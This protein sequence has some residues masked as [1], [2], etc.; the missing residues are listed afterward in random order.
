MVGVG[1]TLWNDA[2][3][4]VQAGLEDNKIEYT[5]TDRLIDDIVTVLVVTVI[6]A[7]LS[8]LCVLS[9][10]LFY[11]HQALA[12][13]STG[14]LYDDFALVTKNQ[15]WYALQAI[16]TSMPIA[17]LSVG[18]ILYRQAHSDMCRGASALVFVAAVAVFVVMRRTRANFRRF[19]AAYKK[20]N[21]KL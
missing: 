21:K 10:Q 17:M 9:T 6:A 13:E 11:F 14:Q 16:L 15:R 2:Q 12:K 5:T 20:K 19:R 1:A 8:A 18:L 7:N 3:G 4:L